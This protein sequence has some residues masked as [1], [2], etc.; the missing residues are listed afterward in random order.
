MSHPRP[1]LRLFLT[2]T[3]VL[4][5]L[6]GLSGCSRI[7]LAYSSADLLLAGYADDYLGLEEDQRERWKPGLKGVLAHH[8]REELPYLASFFDRALAASQA[9]FP[10]SDTACLVTTAREL[11]QRHARLAAALAAPLLADLEPAQVRA[12]KARFARDLAED[13]AEEDNPERELRARAKRYVKAIEEWTGPLGAEQKRLVEEATGRMPDTREAVIAY[14]TR[15]RQALVGLLESDAGSGRL[16]SF[17]TDWLAEYRDLPPD[18]RDAGGRLEE[19]LVE[20]ISTLGQSLTK[21]QKSHLERRLSTL[22]SDLLR[23]QDQPRLAPA[24]C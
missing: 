2:A 1:P 21:A 15:K 16:A 17:L 6:L 4:A 7:R 3:L 20:L 5:L 12:L 8:R 22:K 9:G 19:R 13:L 23:L 18:L 24:T 11:Y 10:A 14:R